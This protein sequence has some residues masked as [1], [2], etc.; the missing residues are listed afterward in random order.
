M[1]KDNAKP[2]KAPKKAP[3]KAPAPSNP[4]AGLNWWAPK[5]D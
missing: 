4:Y 5:K 2:A 1:S 3:K